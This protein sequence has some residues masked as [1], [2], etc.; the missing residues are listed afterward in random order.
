[1]LTLNQVCG[2]K[3]QVFT[4]SP[5]HP[6]LG[7]LKKNH[8]F[9]Y[10]DRKF[11]RNVHYDRSYNAYDS[12]A[13]FVSS[14][15]FNGRPRRNFVSHASRKVFYESTTMFHTCNAKFVLS[16]KN[17]RVIAKKVGAKCKGDKTCIWVPKAIVTNLV[18]YHHC[19]K[20]LLLPVY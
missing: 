11:S 14:S 4:G 10:H 12:H 9:M 15:N 1:M 8:A 16:C 2:F 17:E 13:M 7:A 6:S 5:I 19:S 20:R 18:L 3:F